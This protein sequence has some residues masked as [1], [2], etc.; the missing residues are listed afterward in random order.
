M[1][2]YT[3]ENRG[4]SRRAGLALV[5]V[6]GSLALGLVLIELSPLIAGAIALFT[7]PAAWEFLSDPRATLALTDTRLSWQSTRISGD[8]PLSSIL[9]ARFDTRLDLSHRMTFLLKD[10]RKLRLPHACAPQHLAFED[11]LKARGIAVERHHFALF[12]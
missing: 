8:M 11:A 12:G 7:L 2:D 3:F 10:G 5:L 9:K 1:T 4:R 6:W